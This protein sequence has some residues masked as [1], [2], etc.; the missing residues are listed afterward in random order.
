M[1]CALAAI[2]KRPFHPEAYLHLAEVA[3]EAG[4]VH[5]AMRCLERVL[6]LAP[7]WD[8]P[9]QALETLRNHPAS[10]QPSASDIEWPALPPVESR[11]SVCLIVKD[12]EKMLPRALES[13]RGIAHQIVV[14]DTGSIDRTVRLPEHGAEV[15]HLNGAMT[16]RGTQLCP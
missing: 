3:L 10:Q 7:E 4:N 8:V 15:Y 11:L 14:V 9:M 5:Q 1:E 16:F 12:E 2:T 6:Q 13:V